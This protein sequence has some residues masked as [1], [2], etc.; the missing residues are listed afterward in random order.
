MYCGV[1]CVCVC[2]LANTSFINVV[3][4]CRTKSIDIEPPWVAF[5]FFFVFVLELFANFFV[6]LF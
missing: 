1:L 5:F 3:I 2:N 4:D 6:D